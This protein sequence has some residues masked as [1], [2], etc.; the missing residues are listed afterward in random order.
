MLR[1]VAAA[2]V[3]RNTQI[4]AAVTVSAPVRREIEDAENV[5]LDEPPRPLTVDFFATTMSARAELPILNRLKV[6]RCRNGKRRHDELSSE[7]EIV[8]GRQQ[9]ESL[10][11]SK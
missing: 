2:G 3:F 8:V 1:C 10:K 7:R 5:A 4:E 9:G 6:S 11:Q